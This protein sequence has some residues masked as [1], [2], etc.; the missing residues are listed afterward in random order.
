MSEPTFSIVI[1]AY[2]AA[3]TVGRAVT[4]A[5]EQTEPAA[6]VIVVDDGS[7]DDIVGAL[8][9]FGEKV[10]LIR[11]ENRGAGAARNAAAAAA[12]SEFI[13][14]LDSDD[15]YHPRRLEALGE[16]SRRR[17]T[18]DLLTTDARLIVNGEPA[19][20][21]AELTP[22]AREDQR[23]AIFESCFVGGW[24]AIRLNRFR[25]I[26]GFDETLRIAQDW[27]CW[28]R[29]VLDGAEAGF[30]DE[31]YYDYFLDGD[32]L[33]SSRPASLWERVRMLEKAAGNPSLRDEER[34]ALER[35]LR[36]HRSRAVEAET[37][38]ALYGAGERAK[39]AR[40]AISRRVVPRARLGA[41]LGFLA[42][43]V[44]RRLIHADRPVQERLPA[45]QR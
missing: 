6:E 26:G 1:A 3:D 37:Q 16:L 8:A 45:E 5:L 14:V 22:F 12:S 35:A 31:P 15:V 18:L 28:L 24:P 39:L 34:P 21:F 44:A 7:E 32:G 43:P 25:A 42:P 33:T 40:L 9:P 10:T 27:D 30:V 38:E 2:E 36:L 4:S 17:P 41:A 20:T 19:G 11:Q 29:A 23:R 13:V